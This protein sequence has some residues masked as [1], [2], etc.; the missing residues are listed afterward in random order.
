MF[1]LAIATGLIFS[2]APALQAGRNSLADALH[3]QA[4]SAVGGGN[5]LTRDALVVLQIGAA[6]V[7]L[8]A[9]GLMI[10]T[11]ANLRAIEIGFRPERLLTMRTMLPTPKYA[12]P[13]KRVAFFERAVAN[14]RA[15]P[16]VE[17]AAFAFSP[18]FTTQGNTTSFKIEGVPD[19][20]DRINDAMFRSGT[21][22]YLALLGAQV[23]GRP[24][25]RRT[26]RRRRSAR[27]RHQRNARAR[28]LPE[29]IAARSPDAVRPEHESFYTIVGVVHDIRE[30]GYEPSMKPAVYLS[31]AQAPEIWAIPDHLVVRTRGNPTD[32]RRVGAPRD[33]ERGSRA[34]GHGG[35]SME[36]IIDLEVGR[37]SPEHDAAWRVCRPR[38]GA[39]DA[40]SSTDCWRMRWRSAA[41]GLGLRI[42]LGATGA[43]VRDDGGGA[44]LIAGRPRGSRSASPPA[45]PATPRDDERALRRQADGPVDV[46]RG[47][48][49][50][51]TWR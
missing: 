30:R 21:P 46:R 48:R 4:R 12:D 16:G 40:R 39:G 22:D 51:R 5:R 42:A 43:Q 18:P 38:A 25:D 41:R 33:H 31:I 9:T 24:T 27:R 8:A 10:R 36:E 45:G 11:L 34:A 19:T 13:V 2:L 49:A 32:C 29:S 14:V 1:S 17:R 7:L 28:L 3:S 47:G 26:R 44:R 20:P 50:A 15:L 23:V 6:V 35:A 37:S